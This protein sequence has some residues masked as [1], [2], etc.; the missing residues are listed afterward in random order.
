MVKNISSSSVRNGDDFIHDISSEKIEFSS[1]KSFDNIFFKD[2]KLVLNRLN[3]FL[4]GKDEYAK[5]GISYTL[6]GSLFYG[7]PGCGKT[8]CIKAIA[9]YTKRNLQIINQ[10]VRY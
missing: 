4:E 8:S 10:S 2:K 1:N 5:K 7:E 6:K 9:N 3:K